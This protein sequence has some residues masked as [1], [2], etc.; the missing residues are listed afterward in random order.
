[1][2]SSVK[3]YESDESNPSDSN[4]RRVYFGRGQKFRV[5]WKSKLP[6]RDVTSC[7]A[8]VWLSLDGGRTFIAWISPWMGPK[9][10][11]T[12]PR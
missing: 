5:E 6:L 11:I 8:E 3:Y 7:E 2:G 12:M 9:C 10:A 1:M 4:R